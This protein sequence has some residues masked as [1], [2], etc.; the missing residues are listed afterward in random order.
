FY[1][2]PL[3]PGDRILTSEVEYA[4]NYLAFLQVARR[5]GAVVEVVPSVAT[6]E[7]DLDALERA[8]ERPTALVAITHVPTSSGLV[9]PAAAIGRMTRAA[10]VPFL[11][12]ACQSIG[13]LPLDVEELGCDLLAGTSR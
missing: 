9:N 10:G 8:L 7:V 4:S 3:S 12:D 6:G 1:S 13:Q 5:S 2:V 11:L